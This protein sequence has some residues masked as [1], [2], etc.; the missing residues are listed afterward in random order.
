MYTTQSITIIKYFKLKMDILNF[1]ILI[2]FTAVPIFLMS[3]IRFLID[4][5]RQYTGTRVKSNH[6]SHYIFSFCFSFSFILALL[7]IY[8]FQ[9]STN[10]GIISVE[11]IRICNYLYSWSLLLITLTFAVALITAFSYWFF[12]EEINLILIF[13]IILFLVILI[14]IISST[15]AP[16]SPDQLSS[17]LFIYKSDKISKI[18]KLYKSKF[19]YKLS[20]LNDYNQIYNIYFAVIYCFFFII[21]IYHYSFYTYDSYPCECPLYT[22]CPLLHPCIF[23]SPHDLISDFCLHPSF[24]SANCFS[25]LHTYFIYISSIFFTLAPAPVR[26]PSREVTILPPIPEHPEIPNPLDIDNIFGLQF[27]FEGGGYRANL[28]NTLFG[29][30]RAPFPLTGFWIIITRFSLTDIWGVYTEGIF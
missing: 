23:P 1:I 26:A 22:P 4:L 29:E 20:K 18:F 16:V 7:L 12:D 8:I 28:F 14:L 3:A 11:L 24:Y 30:Y 5:M 13:I 17:G 9:D 2:L 6:S 19:F 15:Y 27:N 10:F 21:L 25:C